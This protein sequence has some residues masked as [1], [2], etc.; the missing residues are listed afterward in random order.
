[1]R[2]RTAYHTRSKKLVKKVKSFLIYSFFSIVLVLFVSQIFLSNILEYSFSLAKSGVGKD[3]KNADKYNLLLVNKNSLNEVLDLS[4]IVFDKS[5]EKL[6]TYEIDVHEENFYM[7]KRVSSIKYLF[8]NSTFNQ[9]ELV[10]SF[11]KNY[12]ILINHSMVFA[13]DEYLL[14]RKTIEGEIKITELKDVLSIKNIG[15]RNTFLMYSYSK[16]LAVEDKKVIKISSIFDLDKELKQ[17]YIDSDI[18]EEKL[19]IAVVNASGINGLG[20]R[21]SRYVSNTG[22]RVID[23]STRNENLEKSFVLYKDDSKTMSYLANILNI[24]NTLKVDEGSSKYNE[25]SELIKADIVIILG[26]DISEDLR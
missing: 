7:D 1:M 3:F 2:R 18:A 14:Y 8:K 15:I 22:G 13:G 10:K 12:G 21:V 26:L 17:I 16:D 11:E 9:D 23:L 24:E 19:S 20:K 4:L 5:N 25:Y 6:F